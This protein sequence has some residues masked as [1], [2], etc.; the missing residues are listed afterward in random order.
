[1]KRGFPAP[2]EQPKRSL[3]HRPPPPSAPYLGDLGSEE[4]GI[5]GPPYHEIPSRQRS[6]RPSQTS[7][8]PS[9]RDQE[10]NEL[11]ASP[12]S[13]RTRRPSTTSPTP[14]RSHSTRSE[15]TVQDPQAREVD[16]LPVAAQAR[17]RTFSDP[18]L[19]PLPPKDV[20]HTRPKRRESETSGRS[21]RSGQR[22]QTSNNYNNARVNDDDDLP[23]LETS[24]RPPRH[25]VLLPEYRYCQREELVKPMRAH[26]CSSCAKVR[27]NLFVSLRLFTDFLG[28]CVLM[29]DHHCPWI[30]Q[31]V[32]AGNHKVIFKRSTL[33]PLSLIDL[34]SSLLFSFNGV[35]CGH[36]GSLQ[37]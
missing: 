2:S 21:Q 30:G 14:K 22:Q 3:R 13:S 17:T 35:H 5:G 7:Q 11:P 1:M 37:H 32:G 15:R 12:T 4:E 25:P 6:R 10:K 33:S 8:T 18:K 16:A 31:C 26:H 19:S 9:K 27:S 34:I 29:Y 23:P 36:Y 24:R 20:P 28:Q